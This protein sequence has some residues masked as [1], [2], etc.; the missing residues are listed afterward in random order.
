MNLIDM[1]ITFLV[2]SADL[3]PPVAFSLQLVPSR[4]LLSF[5]LDFLAALL[6]AYMISE[7]TLG[8]KGESRMLMW[9]QTKSYQKFERQVRQDVYRYLQP[10]PLHV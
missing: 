2:A 1:S 6:T 8:R 5:V 3:V 7:C 10:G 4:P 9:C